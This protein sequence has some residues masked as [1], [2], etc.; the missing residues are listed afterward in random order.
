M[1]RPEML[2]DRL[3][4]PEEVGDTEWQKLMATNIER[5]NDI[6]PQDLAHAMKVLLVHLRKAREGRS[7]YNPHA[8]TYAENLINWARRVDAEKT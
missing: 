8:L 3:G 5:A 7:S 1:Q 6:S 2:S 4:Y